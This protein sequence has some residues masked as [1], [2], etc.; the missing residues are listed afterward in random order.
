MKNSYIAQALFNLIL[1]APSGKGTGFF[2]RRYSEILQLLKTILVRLLN[3]PVVS[4]NLDGSKILLPLSHNLPLIRK[5]HLHY[6]TNV[7]RIASVLKS[8][9]PDLALIDIGAN[10]G[11]TVAILRNRAYFPI[12]CIDGDKHFFSFLNENVK[13]WPDVDLVNSFV[14][15]TT[16]NFSGRIEILGGTG[17]LVEDQ[18]PN[19]ELEIKK[20]SNILC[21]NPRFANAKMIKVDTN[22]FDCKILKSELVLL[23]ALKPVLFFEYDPYFFKKFKDDGFQIFHDLKEIDYKAALVFENTGEYLI[24]L[25]LNNDLLLEDIHQFYSGW[26]GRRYCDICVFHEVD[27]DVFR[28]VRSKEIEFF[29]LA[30]LDENSL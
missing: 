24:H 26:A 11:D 2:W 21:E 10:I 20:L 23:E 22:G 5:S 17:H 19:Q 6:S 27:L 29:K 7:G 4:Y 1:C 9:Y 8:K 13:N 15:D 14:G 18:H 28:Q 12:L 16:G 30:R 3:D 25:N